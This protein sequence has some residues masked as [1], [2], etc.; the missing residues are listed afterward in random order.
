MMRIARPALVRRIASL[1][2]ATPS[3]IPVLV[4]G[5]G[6]GR[7]SLLRAVQERAGSGRAQYVDLERA[8]T[9]PERF[10]RALCLDSPFRA[11]D[12]PLTAAS[13]GPPSTR[14]SPS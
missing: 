14:R 13:P 11:P 2:E 5:C 12:V 8:A 7:T 3:R 4:G 10:H 6:T 1:V 9:T